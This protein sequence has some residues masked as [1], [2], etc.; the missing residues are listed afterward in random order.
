MPY[1]PD[2]FLLV[3]DVGVGEDF[4]RARSVGEALEAARLYLEAAG[5][6]CGTLFRAGEAVAVADVSLASRYDGLVERVQSDL[7]D[8]A[9]GLRALDP[10][11]LAG[12]CE[13][14]ADVLGPVGGAADERVAVLADADW[15]ADLEAAVAAVGALLKFGPG[16]AV[17]PDLAD[18]IEAARGPLDAAHARAVRAA[19]VG[20]PC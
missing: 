20:G 16:D 10:A 19:S 11:G 17:A 5:G 4:Y 2:E 13:V 1:H 3:S 9:G 8:L 14:L 12:R 15:R 6:S 7:A 18:Q